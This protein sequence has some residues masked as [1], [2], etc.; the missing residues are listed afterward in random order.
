MSDNTTRWYDKAHMFMS[1]YLR[2]KK[3]SEFFL[4]NSQSCE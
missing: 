3:N 1:I 2:S 4:K